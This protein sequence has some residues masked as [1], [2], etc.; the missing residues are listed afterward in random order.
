MKP[1]FL[2]IFIFNYF[3]I[4]ANHDNPDYKN[5]PE[6]ENPAISEVNRELP[7]AFFIPYSSTEQAFENNKWESPYIKTLNGTWKFH[8]AKTPDL[9]PLN[10]FDDKFDI[11]NW[12]TIKVPANWEM[13][14]YDI[15]IYTN[16]TYPHEATPPVIQN[17]YNPVGSYKRNFNLPE[18]WKSKEVILHFGG[19]SSA[20]YVW[21]NGQ[22]VGYSEDSKTP[23]EFNITKYLKKGDNSISVEVYRWSDGAYLEDQDFWRLSGMSRDVYLIAR[24]KIHI[25]DYKVSSPLI[26]NYSDGSFKL[27]VELLNTGKIKSEL[28]IEAVIFDGNEEIFRKENKVKTIDSKINSEF[29]SIFKNVKP[30]SAE[31]PDL[32]KLI[33]SLKDK[34]GKIIEVIGQDIGFRTIEIKNAQLLVNG[35]AIYLKGVNIHEHNDTTGHYVDEQTMLRDIFLMKSH[36]LNAVRTSHY[37]QPERWYELCNK[38]GLYLIDEANIESHGMGYGEKSLAKDPAWKDAHL[39]RTRNMYERDKNQPSIIIWSLGN[40]AG[41]GINFEATY[42]YLK[43]VD[44]SRPV[45]Y[46]QAHGGANTDINCP[47][48]AVIGEM[49]KYAKNKPVKPYIQC[50]YAHAMG[51]SVGNL[52]DYWDVIEKYPSLQGGFIWDWVDQGILTKNS[53]GKKYWAYG[54]DLGGDT[55]QNDG[56]F[57]L[58]GIIHPD[59]TIK[60]TI[61]EVGKVYQHIAFKPFEIEKGEIEIHNKYSFT[62]LSEF[63]FYWEIIADGEILK[64]G[65]I[66]DI[67]LDPNSKTTVK[68][69]TTVETKESTEYFLNIYALLKNEK[70]ILP[71]GTKLA[72][73]QIKLIAAIKAKPLSK[74]LLPDLISVDDGR[75]VT[76]KGNNFEI[77]FEKTDG[78]LRS[79]KIDGNEMVLSGPKPN[80]WRAPIDNDFGNGLDI[81]SR[82]W[83]KIDER[84]TVKS[85]VVNKSGGEIEVN[86]ELELNDYKNNAIA[87]YNS[88]Y[89]INGL[90]DI[91]VKNSFNM[92]SD[93]LPEIIRFGVNMEMPRQYEN[94]SWLGRGPHESYNDRFTSALVGLYS[95]KVAEQYFPYIRPQENGNKTDVRWMSITNNSGNG[96]QFIGQFLLSVSAHHNIMEDFESPGR[97]DGRVRQDQKVIRRHTTDVIPRDLTSL[98]IDLMQQGVGGDN[99]WGA[100]T[101]ARYRLTNKTYNYSFIIRSLTSVDNIT[102]KAKIVYQ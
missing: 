69:D 98:N 95:G 27:D 45:Q 32:Y 10:F 23:A 56:N 87:S 88:E 20:M 15:P 26:N 14:G 37:P 99:S 86:I 7:R 51:N 68:L 42:Q 16:I 62:N 18:N 53:E 58:N 70:G 92:L 2:F 93:T 102:E 24:D 8:L 77:K 55:L 63:E 34:T 44:N 84:K 41:N 49:E 50:E 3:F 72:Y 64:K 48:Y 79:Y 54:G 101:H 12:G 31:N 9:R 52:Q 17:H 30:W 82:I 74:E 11:S 76:I 73:E 61:I 91:H 13:L 85:F 57:C 4:T 78:I 38:Y 21:V 29:N 47:M 75:V 90:G 100:K 81:R 33:I 89:L 6:W 60:P 22:K 67:E 43:S 1:I 65:I 80:F 96:L 83:R 97:T 35:V 19:V 94:I 59:R 66:S 71:A 36:N 46:E 5:I 28:S 40:E 39:Y 25:R